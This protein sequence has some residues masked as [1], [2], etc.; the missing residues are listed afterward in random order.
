MSQYRICLE[1]ES[2]VTVILRGSIFAMHYSAICMRDDDE[3]D[4]VNIR[5]Y[6]DTIRGRYTGNKTKM[7]KDLPR[8]LRERFNGHYASDELL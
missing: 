8:S 6:V 5:A 1:G 4:E 3:D 2:V 7:L